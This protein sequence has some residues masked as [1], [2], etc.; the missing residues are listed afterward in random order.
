MAPHSVQPYCDTRV[1]SCARA[2][3]LRRGAAVVGGH[4]RS[5]RIGVQ[6]AFP[7]DVAELEARVVVARVLVVDQPDPVAVVDEVGRQQVVVAGHGA[8]VAGRPAPAGPRRRR[9]AGRRSR[10]G[11]ASRP[12][13]PSRSTGAGSR[14]CRSRRR[15]GRLRAARGRP[16]RSWPSVAGC[17]TSAF[18]SVRP[19]H[20][21]EHQHAI[22][23]AV[24]D[25]GRADPGRG[26][27]QRILVLVVAVDGQQLAAI[28]E[29][30]RDEL[31][32]RRGHLEVLVGQAARQPADLPRRPSQARHP[33][34]HGQRPCCPRLRLGSPHFG[35]DRRLRVIAAKGLDGT[36]RF[37]SKRLPGTGPTW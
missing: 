27:E 1:N 24:L 21:A 29:D 37:R 20:E 25:D 12:R 10:P 32:V 33:G 9:A 6:A 35:H 23:G 13:L 4:E 8:L 30:P 16:R 17:A 19:W 22:L 14:T 15:T 28:G 3:R 7:G 2:I 34:Q 11:C 36:D 5:E 31:A 18:V 26:G